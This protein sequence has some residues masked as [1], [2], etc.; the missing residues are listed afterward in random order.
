MC[1]QGRQENSWTPGQNETWPR[2][3]S[4]NNDTPTKSTTG[5]HKQEIGTTKMN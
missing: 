5:C 3:N 2:S 1:N 4:P